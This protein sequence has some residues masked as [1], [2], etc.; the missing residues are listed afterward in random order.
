M[1]LLPFNRTC[2]SLSYRVTVN[3]EDF[4]NSILCLNYMN[5]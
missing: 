1:V 2:H 4:N 3:D 5:D